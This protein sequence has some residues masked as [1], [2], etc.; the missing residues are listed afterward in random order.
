M[1]LRKAEFSDINSIVNI[2]KTSYEKPY[3]NESLLKYLFND[4]ITDSA[5]IFEL[6][7]NII[8]FLIEQRCLNE[9][10]I[11]N[12]AV[13]K[14]YQNNGFGKIIV[15]QYL[16]ILPNNTV[17]FLEVNINNFIARKIYTSLNFEKVYSRKNYYNNSEDALIMRYVKISN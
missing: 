2:E 16:S 15:S 4:S 5:W 10:S 12:V 7:K 3:W 13:D 11:L 9:I 1:S 17:V 14:K 8:G 6:N